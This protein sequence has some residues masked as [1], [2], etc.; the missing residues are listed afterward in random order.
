M[1][2]GP[3]KQLAADRCD[4]STLF[5]DFKLGI[6]CILTF[7]LCLVDMDP[8]KQR[9]AHHRTSYVDFEAQHSI[10]NNECP[11][12]QLGAD[13]CDQSTLYADFVA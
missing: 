6:R 5:A 8:L 1:D 4:H 10:N 13:R 7:L 3:M 12:K 2:R 11:L 9:E